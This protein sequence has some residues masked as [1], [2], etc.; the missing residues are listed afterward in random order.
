MTHRTIRLALV[1]VAAWTTGA[2][3]QSGT[4]R[5]TPGDTLRYRSTMSG[6]TDTEGSPTGPMQI[7]MT[8]E[9]TMVLAFAPADTVRLWMEKGSMKMTSPMGAMSPPLDAMLNKQWIARMTSNGKMNLVTK[10]ALPTDGM[11]GG[12]VLGALMPQAMQLFPVL[13]AEPLRVG[14]SWPDSAETRTKMHTGGETV[15]RTTLTYTVV[16]DS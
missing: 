12:D 13:P 1:L 4:Y 8:G 14:L 3:A 11:P 16:S 10:P 5:R 15:A 7:S 9:T 6:V 2:A